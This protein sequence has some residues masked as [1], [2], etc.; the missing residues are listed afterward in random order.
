VLVT[1]TVMRGRLVP[2]A[3]FLFPLLLVVACGGSVAVNAASGSGTGGATTS[4]VTTIASTTSS[5]G[6]ASTSASS[7]STSTASSTSASSS[8]TSTSSSSTSGSPPNCDTFGAVGAG[9]QCSQEGASCLMP[10]SCCG[11]GIRCTAGV[12]TANPPTCGEACF[13]CGDGLAC[14]GGICVHDTSVYDFYQCVPNPCS[15]APDCTCAASVCGMNFEQ[16]V[17]TVGS[18]V[19]CGQ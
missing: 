10:Y 18:T 6:S 1:S 14:G 8:S 9:L 15:G 11:A 3:G 16:C 2:A 17:S 19:T 13:D 7:S 4:T 5:S 12:W